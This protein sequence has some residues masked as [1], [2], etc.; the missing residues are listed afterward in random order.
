MYGALSISAG[1]SDLAWETRIHR[2]HMVC[3]RT[4]RAAMARSRQQQQHSDYNSNFASKPLEYLGIAR[5]RSRGVLG[6]IT[7]YYEFSQ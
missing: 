1:S 5:S 3:V 2:I 4:E 6:N 7:F